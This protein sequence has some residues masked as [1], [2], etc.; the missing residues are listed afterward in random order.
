M[1]SRETKRLHGDSVY[2]DEFRKYREEANAWGEG[3][4]EGRALSADSDE[5]I[6]KFG[7]RKRRARHFKVIFEFA[8]LLGRPR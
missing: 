4:R 1:I 2:N 8:I 3:P 5:I 7:S 6:V